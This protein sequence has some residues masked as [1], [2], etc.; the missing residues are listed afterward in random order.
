MFLIDGECHG[1]SLPRRDLAWVGNNSAEGGLVTC[2]CELSGRVGAE[3]QVAE[4]GNVHRELFGFDRTQEIAEAAKAWG[5]NADI[6]VVTVRR[7]G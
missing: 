7:N 4:A 5:Q 3:V 1:P 2:S 6:T